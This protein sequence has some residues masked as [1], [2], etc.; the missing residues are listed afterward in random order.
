MNSKLAIGLGVLALALIV[1][2]GVGGYLVGSQAGFARANQIRTQFLEQRGAGGGGGQGQ[3]TGRAAGGFATGQVTTIAG[4]VIELS[5]AQAAVKVNVTD[6][7]QVLKMDAGALTDIKPGDRITVQGDR[8]ADG[9]ITATRIQ[10]GAF[11]VPAGA[12]GGQ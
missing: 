10:I 11:A 9:T 4:G 2:A 12:Q 1:G 8:Q 6:Q 7:T 5:T 3:G